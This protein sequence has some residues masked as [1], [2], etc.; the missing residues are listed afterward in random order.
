MQQM[1]GDCRI[2]VS[3]ALFLANTFHY[4]CLGMAH[5]SKKPKI[6]KMAF[7]EKRIWLFRMVCAL[8]N[9]VIQGSVFTGIMAWFKYKFN[10]LIFMKIEFSYNLL[11]LI[12][13]GL[14]WLLFLFY[15]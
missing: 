2:A 11:F 9:G 3:V 13:L 15:I 5:F 7:F 1:Y 6:D 8:S 4:I 12:F 10:T 14:L